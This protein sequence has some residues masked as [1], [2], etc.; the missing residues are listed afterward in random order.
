MKEDLKK[1]AEDI[2]SML[3][4]RLTEEEIQKYCNFIN[5]VFGYEK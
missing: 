3:E 4:G 2:L 1:E 5:K